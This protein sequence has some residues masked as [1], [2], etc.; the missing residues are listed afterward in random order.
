MCISPSSGGWEVQ[1][2][3]A[4]RLVF[5]EGLFLGCRLPTSLCPHVGKRAGGALGVSFIGH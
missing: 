1:D 3:G 5:G 4:G 2:Q